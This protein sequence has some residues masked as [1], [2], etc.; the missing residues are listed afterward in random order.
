MENQ[1]SIEHDEIL[2]YFKGK[3]VNV[4]DP[5]QINRINEQ[6]SLISD[7]KMIYDMIRNNP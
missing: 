4:T 1:T 5:Q 3:L 2:E 6:I 7:A